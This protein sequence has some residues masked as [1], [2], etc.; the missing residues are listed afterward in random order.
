[1][2]A[3]RK[4]ASLEPLLPPPLRTPMN[5]SLLCL[6]LAATLQAAACGAETNLGPPARGDVADGSG[7]A[8]ASDVTLDDPAPDGSGNEGDAV[9]PDPDAE[10]GVGE[11][12]ADDAAD[13]PGDLA[14]DGEDA[15]TDAEEDAPEDTVDEE[16]ATDAVADSPD[17]VPDD[18]GTPEVVRLVLIGDFGEGNAAQY[19]VSE[20]M[21]RHCDE[22]GGCHGLVALGDNIYDT[23]PSS[24]TDPQFETK[25]TAPYAEL[26]YGAPPAEGEEDARPRLPMYVSLGNHDLGGAGLDA[27]LARHYV[28]Y[29]RTRDWFYFP[30]RTWDLRLG[31][32]HLIALDTNPLAYLGTETAEQGAL[33]DRVVATTEAQWTVVFGHHPYRSNGDHGNAGS[34]EGFPGDLVFL[35]GA[36]RRFVDEH[37][38]NDVDFYI[39]G[40]DHNRQWMRSVPRIPTWP[41]FPP[42]RTTYACAT[43]FAISGAGAK[44]DDLVDRGNDLAFGSPSEG[45]LYMEFRSDSVLAE[46]ADIDGNVEWSETFR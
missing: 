33:I 18:G 23:G 35:G 12:A 30:S 16:I 1:M 36:F 34:Y 5:R 11:D 20:S 2:T 32:V 28:E 42:P 29:G 26:R 4:P 39:S 17:D 40:H 46:F 9:E 15:A 38:C 3:A 37:I 22:R 31:P 14:A 43:R 24:A 7:A 19:R 13:A 8:D 41:V 6:L 21:G 27:S 44:D 10:A 45:F 25:M